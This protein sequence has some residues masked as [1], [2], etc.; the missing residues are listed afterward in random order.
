MNVAKQ[1]DQT[2]DLYSFMF[3]N[4]GIT[5]NYPAIP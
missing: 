2:A 4:M 3:F 1:L 5:P